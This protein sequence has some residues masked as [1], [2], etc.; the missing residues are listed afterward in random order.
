[1]KRRTK[2]IWIVGFI[3]LLWYSGTYLSLS[4]GGEYKLTSC[5]LHEGHYTWMPRGFSTAWKREGKG[6]MFASAPIPAAVFFPCVW[7]DLKFW[8]KGMI[9]PWESSAQDAGGRLNLPRTDRLRP[10]P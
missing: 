6:T 9:E 3:L 1:M 8:H 2:N 7:C 4:L 5:C 10:S